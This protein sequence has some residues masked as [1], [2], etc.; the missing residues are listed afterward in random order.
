MVVFDN[1]KFLVCC[2]GGLLLVFDFEM[3]VVIVKGSKFYN[4]GM[5]FKVFLRNEFGFFDVL[6]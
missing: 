5:E 3:E 6:E 2:Y 4:N 1:G